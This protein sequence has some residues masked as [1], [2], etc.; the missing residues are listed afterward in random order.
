VQ[1]EAIA[2]SIR[3]IRAALLDVPISSHNVQQLHR[4]VRVICPIITHPAELGPQYAEFRINRPLFITSLA[5]P[6]IL[7]LAIAAANAL[8][9]HKDPQL[10]LFSAIVAC[11][12]AALVLISNHA[13]WSVSMP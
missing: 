12:A 8:F 10:T 3:A 5:L 4:N 13:R 6:S 7:A 1:L 11:I 2:N 9:V